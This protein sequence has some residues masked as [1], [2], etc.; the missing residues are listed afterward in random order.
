MEKM[1]NDQINELLEKVTTGLVEVLSKQTEEAVDAKKPDALTDKDLYC[2]AMHIQDY[3]KKKQAESMLDETRPGR[4][5]EYYNLGLRML[6]GIFESQKVPEGHYRHEPVKSVCISVGREFF[7]AQ[8]LI[9]K[10]ALPCMF[11]KYESKCHPHPSRANEYVINWWAK[12][13]KLSEITGV[14]IDPAIGCQR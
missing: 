8:Y 6:K 13:R 9:D 3:V 1:T 11:C 12:F 5:N 2:I 10:E 14:N 7:R 4:E